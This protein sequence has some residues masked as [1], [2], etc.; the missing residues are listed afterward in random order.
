MKRL[1]SLLL[2]TVLLLS[3]CACGR[4]AAPAAPETVPGVDESGAWAGRGGCY[5]VSLAEVPEGCDCLVLNG[6]R[7]D[8]RLDWEKARLLRGGEL[9]WESTDPVYSVSAC[10]EGIWFAG[11]RREDGLITEQATLVD[12]EGRVLRELNLSLPPDHFPLG[13]LERGEKLYLNS[14]SAVLIYDREGTMLAQ[15]PHA[16]WTGSLLS[17]A[18]GKAYFLEEGEH[19]GSLS[20]VNAE[21]G[22]LDLLFSYPA[23]TLCSGDGEAPFFLLMPEGIYRLS[24]SGETSPLVLWQECGLSVNGLMKVLPLEDGSYLLMGVAEPL[25]MRPAEPSELRPRV[26]LRLGVLPGEGM[27]INGN[28]IRQVSAFNARS[29][30]AYVELVDLSED[31]TLSEDQAL[32]RLNTQ[33][34]AGDG[35]DMLCFSSTGALTPFPYLRKGLLR[36]LGRDLAED[37]ELREE[38][39]LTAPAIRSDFGG[40]YLLS[41]GFSMEARLG[42]RDRF[43]DCW[44]WSFTQ[45]RD[46]QQSLPGSSLMMYN[47]TREEFL[48]QSLSRYIRSAVDWQSGRCDFDNEGFVQLLETCRDLRE[49]PEDPNNMVFGLGWDMLSG[50]YL[51]TDLCMVASVGALAA[52]TR[53]VPQ[54]VSVVGWPTP[55]GSCGTDLQL[56]QAIGVLESSVHPA[57]CWAFLKDLLTHSDA[58]LPAYR[59]LYEQWIE[60]ARSLDENSEPIPYAENLKSPLTEEEIRQLDELIGRIEHCT[61][62]DRTVMDIARQE[63][64]AFL[65]GDKSAGETAALIQSRVSVYLSEQ[66]G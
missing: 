52:Y 22:S 19:G 66:S 14:S 51:A 45:F 33:L 44:G 64:A 24:D 5:S 63:A 29:L 56:G 27:S 50:G 6:Q 1:F 26:C 12:P 53:N 15:I 58:S 61:M 9:L 30:D 40:L 25:L 55:D 38:D 16:E 11:D 23:G 39:I 31:G 47:M 17:G 54:G 18:D 41:G 62:S 2:C 8:F 7:Y 13:F 32:T 3:L 65:A 35:L 48:R 21:S 37:G 4:E 46:M 57:E 10:S 28:L 59:P 42:L 34:L 43:G 20:L 60:K 49:T 36:D